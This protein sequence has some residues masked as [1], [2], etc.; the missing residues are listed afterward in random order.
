[1]RTAASSS[2]RWTRHHAIGIRLLRIVCSDTNG[3]IVAGRDSRCKLFS[4]RNGADHLRNCDR[5]RAVQAAVDGCTAVR[6]VASSAAGV[7]GN[8][9]RILAGGVESGGGSVHGAAPGGTGMLDRRIAVPAAQYS[10]NN[11]WRC[12]SESAVTLFAYRAGRRRRAGGERSS[13]G[14]CIMS[15]RRLRSMARHTESCCWR[16]WCCWQ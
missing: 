11:G 10:K 13:H 3:R 9:S 8:K 14:G 4:R 1:M 6:P 15:I 7:G 5:D 12:E 2:W 16:K